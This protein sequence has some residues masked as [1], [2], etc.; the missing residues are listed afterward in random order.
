MNTSHLAVTAI[1]CT[2]LLTLPLSGRAQSTKENADFKLALNLYNDGLYDLA[3]E[4]LKQFINTFSG[5]S[6]GIEAKFYLGLTE[7]KLKQYDDARL[8]FQTFALTYQDNPKAPDAWLNVGEC[9]VALKSYKEAALAFERVKVFHSKS[10]VAPEALVK[11]STYFKLAGQPDDARRVL[12]IALQ[13]YA[14]SSA[15]LP[16]RTLLGQMYF[17]EGNLVQAQNELKRVIEGDPSPEATAQALL[18]LGNIYQAM[19]QVGQAQSSYQKII[20]QHKSSAAAVQGAYLNLG[21][22]QSASGHF[23]EAI[24]SFK[25][26]LAEKNQTDSLLVFEAN[27]GIG[28]NYVASGD[29][30]G[31]L[32]YYEKAAPF[33]SSSAEIYATLWKIAAVAAQGKSFARSNDACNRILKSGAPENV[34]KSAAIR[35]A[36]NA[37]AQNDYAQ[38]VQYY[39]SFLDQH[40]SDRFADEIAFRIAHLTENELREPRKATSSYEQFITRYPHS[41]LIDDAYVGAARSYDALKEFDR[42]AQL[43]REML[44][45]FPSSEFR[46]TAEGR[47]RTIETFEAKEKDAGVEKLALLLGDMVGDSDKVGLS[48]RLGEIYFNELKNY[49]AAAV[50]FSVA[51]NSAMND[52]RFVDALY[53]R[54]RSFEYLSWRDAKYTTQA[55]EAYQTFLKSYPNEARSNDA[56]LALFMLSA[57]S[58]QEAR[59]SYTALHAIVP[60]LRGQDVILQRIGM[61]QEQAD[62]AWAALSTYETLMRDYKNSPTIIEVASRRIPLLLALG[63][64]DSAMHE[65]MSYLDGF[66]NGPH[67]AEVTARLADML[68]SESPDRAAEYYRRLL[69]NFSYTSY[70]VD[71]STKLAETYAATGKYDEAISIYGELIAGQTDNPLVGDTVAASLLCAIGKTHH[72]AGNDKEA[73]EYLFKVIA[74]EHTGEIAGVAYN[75]LGM[76]ARNEGSP[77]L[78][79]SYF[80][81]AASVTPSA[82]ASREV[83]DLLFDNAAYT[84]AIRQYALLAQSA[85]SDTDRQ[86]YDARIIVAR[87]RNDDNVAAERELNSFTKK[88]KD[89]ESD[90]ASFELEKGLY[91]YRR[92]E[93]VNARK[94]FDRVMDKYDDSPS[95]PYAMYWIGKTLESTQKQQEALTQ[96]EAL[97]K[98]YPGSPVTP[99]VHLAL[100]NIYYDLEKWDECIRNYKFI[101]D[102]RDADPSLLPVAMSN[103]IETY[104]TAGIF[105]AALQLTRKYLELYPNNEDSFDKKI[106]IGILYQRLGYNEQSALHLQTLL[107]QA[108]SDLE[109]EIRYYIAEA[110][111][112]K[113]DFQQAIL[114]FLKVPYLVTKKGK[115]DWTANSLYMAGQSYEKMGRYDQALTMYTQITERSGIDETFKAAAKKEIDRVKLVL[116]K[117]GSK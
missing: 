94:S 43:Y 84:D 88:Y 51:I 78:A 32:A 18:I 9:Y 60:G 62:S 12:R 10:K 90:A 57:T 23:R 89:A 68:R 6:N 56:A 38:A 47:I 67:S 40:A 37:E 79:T 31:A 14:N 102:S 81:Q 101:V 107:D 95:A 77:D 108:G 114:D 91:Y 8:T 5:T 11:A 26:A 71:A 2:A 15:A 53:Y 97:M 28:D 58:L 116:K 64:T 115:V 24:E 27:T 66:P 33:A 111:Y 39:A 41:R 30:T 50:Q 73:K 45:K 29:V 48:F 13:E 85:G 105:D 110:N 4:Q 109:G 17:E 104:E 69:E 16:A 86:Y 7:M 117:P 52:S 34:K 87:Y 1:V 92:E 61:L 63:L 3:A 76:I 21:K 70:A 99:R 96:Y 74:R 113:G 65:S 83:A 80:R 54:A 100:G 93:Y 42:A 59:N 22:L 20:T 46:Q 25:K 44:K 72:L 36:I 112:N 98:S 103:L 82:L 49:S 19:G 106:K 35:L 75:L 55:I